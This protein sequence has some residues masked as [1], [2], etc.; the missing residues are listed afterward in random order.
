MPSVHISKSSIY[1]SGQVFKVG[2]L[3]ETGDVIG[4]L[5]EAFHE[6]VKE[7]MTFIVPA[8]SANGRYSVTKE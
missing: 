2:N 8:G 4:T 1:L 5:A 3:W 6:Y 7:R